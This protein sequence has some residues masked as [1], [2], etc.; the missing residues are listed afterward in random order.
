MYTFTNFFSHVCYF[1][2]TNDLLRDL[3]NHVNA[4]SRPFNCKHNLR[5]INSR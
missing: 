3:L 1:N 4:K 2:S 5:R